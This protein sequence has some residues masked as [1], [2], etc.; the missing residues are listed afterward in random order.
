MGFEE[1]KSIALRVCWLA[2]APMCERAH[3]SGVAGGS[4]EA[5][6][7]GD[8]RK[9]GRQARPPARHPSGA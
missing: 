1:Y 6:S 4:A 8:S 2:E 7:R 3:C 9:A 5:S